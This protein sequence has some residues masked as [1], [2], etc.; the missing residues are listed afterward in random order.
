MRRKAHVRFGEGRD[1]QT[2]LYGWVGLRL[3]YK[4][5]FRFC[6]SVA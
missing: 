1:R 3:F 5:S 4:S 2:I 6:I